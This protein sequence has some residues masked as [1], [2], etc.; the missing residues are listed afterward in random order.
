[1]AWIK[2]FLV[3]FLSASGSSNNLL[4]IPIILIYCTVIGWILSTPSIGVG[5]L[6]IGGVTGS[7]CKIILIGLE[8]ASGVKPSNLASSSGIASKIFLTLSRLIIS[9]EVSDFSLL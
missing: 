9:V 3:S 2:L 1:M 6:V 5:Y 7:A 4:F 8:S